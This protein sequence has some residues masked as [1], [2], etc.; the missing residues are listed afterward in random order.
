[1]SAFKPNVI[2]LEYTPEITIDKIK[3]AIARHL[4]SYKQF[5]PAFT[6]VTELILGCDIVAV[7]RRWATAIA[8]VGVKHNEAANKTKIKISGTFRVGGVFFYLLTKKDSLELVE[9]AIR[10]E[11][12]E[13]IVS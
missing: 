3:D 9:A 1:M 12:P 2:E 10:E 4:P 7:K 13:M 11:L 5:R 8:V 6:G